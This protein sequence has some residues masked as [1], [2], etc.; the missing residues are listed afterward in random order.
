MKVDEFIA[1]IRENKIF[2]PIRA[3]E[4]RLTLTH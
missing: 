1:D 4:L 3:G 2:G